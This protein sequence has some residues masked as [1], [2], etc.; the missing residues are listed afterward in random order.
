M[1]SLHEKYRPQVLSE[2]IGNR[3]QIS[4]IKKMI[5]NYSGKP[6]FIHGKSGIGKNLVVELIA[7]EIDFELV[8]LTASDFRDYESI[9]KTIFQSSRHQSILSESSPDC[10]WNGRNGKKGKIILIDELDIVD[11][12]MIKGLKEVIAESPFPIVLIAADPYARKLLEL[13]RFSVLVRMDKVRS[14]SLS[15]FLKR[16]SVAEGLQFDEKSLEQLARMSDGDV[17][18]ALIDMESIGEISDISLKLLGDRTYEQPVFETLKILFKTTSIENSR[19][20]LEH[21]DKSS[22]ELFWWVEENAF[23]EYSHPQELADA[24]RFL[25]KADYFQSLIIRRQSWSLMKY[26]SDM[27]CCISIAKR[28]SSR[29]FVSYQPPRFFARFGNGISSESSSLIEKLGRATHTSK[30]DAIRYIPLLKK[31]AKSAKQSE[32]LAM[33]EEE[34]EI[35]KDF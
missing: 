28:E 18:A 14:D 2:I 10:N 9:K 33:T 19:F 31:F 32:K 21:S 8:Q 7:K 15:A 6:I 11:S 26:F 30:K 35:I 27:L 20:A 3:L 12:G 24:Y 34:R 23:R 5:E 13:R 1:S 29:K 22:D 4:D 16:V 17:R 25:S